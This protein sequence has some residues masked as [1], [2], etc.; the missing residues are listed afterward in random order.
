[1]SRD[2][3]TS[4]DDEK[5][6][7]P[8]SLLLAA[9]KH[10]LKEPAKVAALAYFWITAVGFARTFGNTMPFG[11]NAIDL[12]SPSDFLLAGLRDPLVVVV[13]AVSA[14]V[15]YMMWGKALT[16]Q[17]WRRALGPSIVV[18]L[19]ISVFGSAWYRH[20]VIA[21][22]WRDTSFAPLP[23]TVTFDGEQAAMTDLRL[24]AT[25][26]EFI[27]FYRTPGETVIVKRDTILRMEL[28]KSEG[29]APET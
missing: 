11:I 9:W 1:M 12:A 19:V 10:V 14:V 18:I 16:S 23:M 13:A 25:T 15:L 8:D 5:S 29:P 4:N 6:G 3:D 24:V 27:I 21:G 22:P 7:L 26:A 2:D 20:R 17:R 28:S